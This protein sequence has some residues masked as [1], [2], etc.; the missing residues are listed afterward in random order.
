MPPVGNIYLQMYKHSDQQ[1]I[2][3]SYVWEAKR[4][5]VFFPYTSVVA[6]HILDRDN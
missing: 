5:W 2:S 4:V 3:K 1:S 6:L